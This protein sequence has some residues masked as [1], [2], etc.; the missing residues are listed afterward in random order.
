MEYL[1]PKC[2]IVLENGAALLNP[3]GMADVEASPQLKSQSEMWPPKLVECRKC[4]TCGHSETLEAPCPR[5]PT[6]PTDLG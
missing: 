4:P 2:G 1:C 6:I 3:R 5:G